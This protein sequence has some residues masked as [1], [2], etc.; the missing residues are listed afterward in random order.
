MIFKIYARIILFIPLFLLVV[1][2]NNLNINANIYGN[3][4]GI[5]N[6]QE[7]SFVFN[8]DK[9]CVLKFVDKQSNLVEAINGEYELD[10]SKKPIPLTI[11]NIPQLA[12][13]LYT[14]VEFIS[15]D[16][17]RMAKFSLYLVVSS[18]A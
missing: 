17:I 8:P 11:R 14:I 3:W 15:D 4:E 1:S 6:E 7:L 2:C 16:S 13:P 5:Y 12:H 9:I 18:I 10:F